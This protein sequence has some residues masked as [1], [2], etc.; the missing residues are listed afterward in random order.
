MSVYAHK[1]IFSHCTKK[2][3]LVWV[4]VFRALATEENV[5]VLEKN[6]HRITMPSQ[7]IWGDHR[8]GQSAWSAC[9]PLC[10]LSQHLYTSCMFKQLSVTWSAH[11]PLCHLSQHLYTSCM[12]KQLSVTWSAHLPLCHLSQHLYTSCMFKQCVSQL[13]CP[14]S[15]LS[16]VS[17]P[18]HLLFC[19]FKQPAVGQ[20]VYLPSSLSPVSAPVHFLFC[21]FK[22]NSQLLVS[23]STCLPLC[24]CLS[25]CTLLILYV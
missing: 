10:H 23:W 15:S 3:M 24:H 8:S 7:L 14:P 20:L 5:T 12:F 9:L 13:V 1:N 6:C 18:V 25:T 2:A 17:A 4:A 22:L 11:L 16:P 21:M 19:M